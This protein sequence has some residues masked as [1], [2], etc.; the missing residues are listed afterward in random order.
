M[1]KNKERLAYIREEAKGL[2]D[3]FPEVFEK[4]CTAAELYS[5]TS[6]HNAYDIWTATN[7]SIKQISPI[8]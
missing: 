6:C 3:L 7:S 8:S 2:S 4:Y 5:P 1:P